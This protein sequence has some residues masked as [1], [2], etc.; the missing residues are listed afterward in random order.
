MRVKF[1]GVR[2]SIPTP[3]TSVEIRKKTE[4]L[5]KKARGIDLNDEAAVQRFLD[6][7]SI[8]NLG[9]VGGNTACVEVRA[10]DSLLIFDAGSGLRPLGLELMKTEFAAG[11]CQADI[12]LGHTHWDHI[13][14]F[15]FF[16]PAFIPGNRINIYGCHD[17]LERRIADQQ[18]PDHFPV[19][20][21]DMA[22]QKSF[23][24][25]TPGEPIEIGG[26][27]I[28]PF[29]MSHPGEAYGYRV[30]FGDKVFVYASDTEMKST[31]EEDT[32]YFRDAD[33]LVLDTMYTIDDVLVKTD[34]GHCSSLIGIDLAHA[35][36]VR[37]LALFHHEPTYDDG[38]LEG[39]VKKSKKYLQKTY[40]EMELE[41]ILAC[42]GMEIQI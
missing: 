40:P 34:W 36:G 32:K 8:F 15:P 7:Q 19:S 11:G 21:D 5:L 6:G 13:M 22:S 38:K 27:R 29:R 30:E 24:T 2:G 33:L 4:K 1:W 9:T 17:D 12:F 20:L 14:G 18:A 41:I 3:I 16:V 42:E 26:A 39:I 28:A 25:L 23:N 31:G 37:R 10:G 35:E